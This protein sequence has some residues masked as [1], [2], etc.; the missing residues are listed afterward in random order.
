MAIWDL[1]KLHDFKQPVAVF[2]EPKQIKKLQYCP[3][4]FDFL[5][6]MATAV[7][8]SVNSS[9][10]FLVARS[11]RL[12]VLTEGSTNVNVYRLEESAHGVLKEPV[13]CE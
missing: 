6:S 3:A 2:E 12:A 8:R 1:R 4:R 10:R 5:V 11:N 9:T 7:Q 13:N